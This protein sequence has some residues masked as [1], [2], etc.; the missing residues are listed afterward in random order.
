MTETRKYRVTKINDYF[1][2]EEFHYGNHFF[3]YYSGSKWGWQ[4]TKNSNS[5]ILIK[6]LLLSKRIQLGQEFEMTQER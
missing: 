4:E 5:K 1:K 2:T 3:E 6:D